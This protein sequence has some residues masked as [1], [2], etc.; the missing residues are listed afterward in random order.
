[1]R[2]YFGHHKCGSTWI[3]EVTQ[4][5]CRQI[6]LRH[7]LV[8]AERT[9]EGRGPLTAHGISGPNAGFQSAELRQRAEGTGAD[10]VSCINANRDQRDGLDPERAFHVIR[11]PRDVIVS[12]YFSHRNSH[13]I[14]SQPLLAT[15]RDRLRTA[16]LEDGL[17]ME[18]DFARGDLLELGD[19]DYA[20]P[21][22]LE[23]RLEELA[24]RPYEGF[25]EIFGHLG[26]LVEEEPTKGRQL[27]ATW[28]R[29]TLNRLSSRPG[30]GALRRPMPASGEILLGAVYANRFEAKSKGRRPGTE[31]TASHYR[32][33]VAGDW[34]NHFTDMHVEA[35]NER[36]GDLL[37]RLGYEADE[38]WGAER[39]FPSRDALAT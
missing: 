39:T 24:A 3:W 11:D 29:R 26:L 1:M 7:W 9:S 25:L 19:W 31:D 21:E 30:L 2:A 15:H 18:M 38:N 23:L 8:L 6:G 22:V 14:D 32:K 10:L 12:G 34:V 16:S 5:A 28:L 4:H 27:A 17:V 36:F 37:Q 35:F 20:R 13:P 33:G